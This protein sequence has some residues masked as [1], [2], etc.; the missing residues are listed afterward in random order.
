MNFYIAVDCEGVACAVGSP[1]MALSRESPNY[2]FA[3]EQA[4]R[5]ASA[6][7]AAL[8]DAGARRV[9]VWDAHS[10]G[11]NLHYDQLDRRCDIALGSGFSRRLPG[12]DSSFAGLLFI[13]YHAMDETAGAVLAH[14]MSSTLYQAVRINGRA[15]GEMAIDAAVAGEHGVPVIFASSDDKGVA[16]ARHFF[17]GVAAI[18]TKQSFGWNCAVSKHPLRVLDEITQKVRE[19]AEQLHSGSPEVFRFDSPLAIERRYKRLE[20]AE[21]AAADRLAGW[22]RLDPYTVRKTLASILDL[23]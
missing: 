5:E 1:G 14:T 6:A 16:E 10:G 8:F 22:E 11:L 12:L 15:V 9:V 19:V 17:P 18:A 4:T 3:C 23:Y 13:G 7:A 2:A 21:Q 20:A